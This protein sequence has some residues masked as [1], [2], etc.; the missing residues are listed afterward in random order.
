MKPTFKKI[1]AYINRKKRRGEN[2]S[3]SSLEN[4][5]VKGK[6][7]RL[8]KE[9]LTSLISKLRKEGILVIQNGEID[10]S[11]KEPIYGIVEQDGKVSY[12]NVPVAHQSDRLLKVYIPNRLFGGVKQGDVVRIKLINYRRNKFF[13]KPI[14]II[15]NVSE[16]VLGRVKQKI[17]RNLYLVRSEIE[18]DGEKSTYIVAYS[19]TKEG[20]KVGDLVIVG[21]MD[22]R[23]RLEI[24]KAIL[25][26]SII[27]SVK[28]FLGNIISKVDKDS[29]QMLQYIITC[30]KYELE[31]YKE[32][33]LYLE[34][35]RIKE[36]YKEW[37][38]KDFPDTDI[39]LRGLFTVTIDGIEAKDFDDAISIERKDGKWIL[40]VHIADVSYWVRQ[41]SFLDLEARRRGTSVYLVENVVPMLPK[42][43]SEDICSLKANEPRKCI[44]T[45]IELN[46]R[47]EVENVRFY[48]SV[49]EVNNRLT[50]EW[51]ERVLDKEERVDN[52]DLE[53]FL[54][55]AY[56]L[57]MMLNSCRM[58]D[59]SIDLNIPEP[60]FIIQEGKVKDIA[61]TKRLKSHRIIEEFM[62]I[63][64]KEVAK[65]IERYGYPSIYRVHE[66]ID[67]E[68]L[69]A[70]ERIANRMGYSFKRKKNIYM[71]IKEFLDSIAGKPE[72][73]ILNYLFLRSMKIAKYY[74]ESI[75]HFGLGFLSYTHFTSPIRRYPDL[76][77]HRVLKAIMERRKKPYKKKE[78]YQI[79]EESS[80]SERNAVFAERFYAKLKSAEYMQD[81]IGT[82]YK[83]MIIG[84]SKTSLFVELLEK[85]IEGRI[86]LQTL[87]DDFYVVDEERQI[88]IGKR[89]KRVFEIGDIREVKLVSVD[90]FNGY[91]DFEF[92]E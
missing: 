68:K 39:D 73:K 27:R 79:A 90:V 44:S 11:L 32:E 85:P 26:S 3:L 35:E 37:V 63:C 84:F 86:A 57:A 51:V 36:A 78:L 43:L 69:I 76:I 40:W 72:E 66:D 89:T 92:V 1:L 16:K 24:S 74:P 8:Y 91:I 23:D 18:E 34:E 46:G 61:Y 22:A 82:V 77:V 13:G 15:K 56:K 31:P 75:G 4:K 47:G 58:R 55:D 70:F 60:Y 29:L 50:Y 71:A 67:E 28:F 12:I 14:Y 53:D 87:R 52:R 21:E 38:N 81:K 17:G 49:I 19:D 10:L 30:K 59:G 65:Y 80:L 45:R 83:A 2:I 41:G 25:S 54:Y 20:Y 64:N 33:E 6:K 62:L 9:Q 7:K 42:V 5:F 88:A 48:K